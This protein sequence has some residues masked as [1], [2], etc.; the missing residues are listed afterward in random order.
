M[1]QAANEIKSLDKLVIDDD[2]KK[3]AAAA[4]FK[5][6]QPEEF[7]KHHIAKVFDQYF[8]CF[9]VKHNKRRI[10]LAKNTRKLS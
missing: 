7:Y 1:T 2:T 6:L 4:S 5:K 10:I 9:S 3:K 8:P